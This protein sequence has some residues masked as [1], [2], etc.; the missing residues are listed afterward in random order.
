MNNLTPSHG[1]IF[2][3]LWISFTLRP[4]D[5]VS[6][7]L[8]LTFLWHQLCGF[9]L[10]EGR[11]MPPKTTGDITYHFCIVPHLQGPS[12]FITTF[13]P[14]NELWGDEYYYHPCFID[15]DSDDQSVKVTS[16]IPRTSKW[17]READDLNLG[18]TICQLCD[19]YFTYPLWAKVFPSVSGDN[20][21]NSQSC[22]RH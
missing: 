5:E 15:E 7:M 8:S 21:A 20:K 3:S 10:A 1:V 2:F 14:Y 19:L 18:S 13:D 6:L 9:N 11:E 12:T 4:K 17:Q 16:Q 22:Y